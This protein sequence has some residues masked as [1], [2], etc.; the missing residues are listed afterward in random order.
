MYE[1]INN[2]VVLARHI[3]LDDIKN[4]LNFFSKDSDFLQVGIWGNYENGK[5]LNS[6]I[7]NLA[8]RIINR[9]HEVLYVMEG[10]IKADIYDLNRNF[11]E[12]ITISKGEI[13]VL[14]ECGHGYEVTSDNT[15]VLEIK[16]GPYLGADIDRVRF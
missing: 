9:T 7:H 12:T 8:D 13:L 5:I 4:G 3:V 11:V 6:H 15:Y 1:I 14:M 2:N 16:N 10:S